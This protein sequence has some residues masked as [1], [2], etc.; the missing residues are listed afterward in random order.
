ME[1]K[2]NIVKTAEGSMTTYR[3]V[4]VEVADN[5]AICQALTEAAKDVWPYV[6]AGCGTYSAMTLAK[7]GANS[8]PKEAEKNFPK[9]LENVFV[10]CGPWRCA[11]ENVKSNLT[12][13]FFT[14]AKFETLVGMK[15]TERLTLTKQ[16]ELGALLST[17]RFT[18]P[19]DIKKIMVH[20]DKSG[21]K[22]VYFHPHL[23]LKRHVIVATTGRTLVA[24]HIALSEERSGKLD[25]IQWLPREVEKMAGQEVTVEFYKDGTRITAANDNS[26]TLDLTEFLCTVPKWHTVVPQ[27]TSERLPIDATAMKKAINAICVG[28]SADKFTLSAEQGKEELSL[29]YTDINYSI[30]INNETKLPVTWRSKGLRVALSIPMTKDVLALEPTSIRYQSE[31]RPV[32]WENADTLILEMPRM[33]EG[34]KPY[35][36]WQGPMVNFPVDE[37]PKPT[38]KAEKKKQTKLVVKQI[39]QPTPIPIKAEPAAPASPSPATHTLSFTERL[40]AALIAR[41]AAAA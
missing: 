12:T 27:Q 21:G 10:V 9:E 32:V 11:I 30:N 23:D 8:I 20:T 29:S 40:R 19:K 25:D 1:K 31:D 18:V 39:A 3:V 5:L 37:P 6:N 26:Y 2:F 7:T 33:P 28:G 41:I 22:E 38:K 17:V 16:K 15:Q 34:E 13:L 4:G 14:L 36:A 35:L 24:R